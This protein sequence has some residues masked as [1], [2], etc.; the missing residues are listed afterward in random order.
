MSTNTVMLTDWRPWKMPA[1]KMRIGS[2][3]EYRPGL[4]QNLWL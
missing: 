4:P 3:S 1:I 2:G